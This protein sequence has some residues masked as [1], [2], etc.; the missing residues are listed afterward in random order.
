MSSTTSLQSSM[1]PA[2]AITRITGSVPLSR[3]RILPSPLSFASPAFTEYNVTGIFAAQGMSAF[4]H[5]FK[6]VLIAHCGLADSCQAL[7]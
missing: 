6:Y 5:V 1:V 3:R 2:S 7:S 4:L